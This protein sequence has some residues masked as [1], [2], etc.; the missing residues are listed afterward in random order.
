MSALLEVPAYG[1]PEAC[2]CGRR[3]KR[4]SRRCIE[5]RRSDYSFRPAMDRFMEKVS[6]NPAGCWSWT[7]QVEPNGYGK[8][9]YRGRLRWAHRVAY[10]LLVG[11][12]PDGMEVCHHCDN[13]PC[14]NPAH[15][16]A[17]THVENARDAQAKG[18]LR[19]APGHAL[20]LDPSRQMHGEGHYAA[21]LTEDMVRDIRRRVREGETQTDVA[22]S[23]G[24]HLMTVNDVV[25]GRTWRHVQ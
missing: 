11:P 25:R 23:V 10:E 2:R 13:P 21:R 19:W 6:I 1:T 3:K 4:Q 22:R 8:F 5:C 24:V 16:F 15:L 9:Y 7:G 14:V 18:R 12:I 17:G 20:R